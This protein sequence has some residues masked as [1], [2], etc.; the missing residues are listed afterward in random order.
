MIL[1]DL[2]TKLKDLQDYL[3][4][5]GWLHSE[6]QIKSLEKPGEGNMNVVLRI[7][8]D[9]RSFI[10][11]QSRPYVEKYK[12]IEAPLDR[13]AVEYKFYDI[14]QNNA[15]H[16]HMPKI[17]GY[18][19]TNHLLLLEDLGKCEDMIS[20]YHDGDV[21]KKML[22]KLIFILRIIHRTKPPKD[23][24]ENFAMRK[25]N[26][27]H[28]FSLPFK[29]GNGFSLSDIQPGLQ[30]LSMA[31][32]K[33]A[34]LKKVIKNIGKRYLS[35]GNT[36]IHGDYYPGSWMTETENLYV[37]DPEFGFVGF[38]EFDLGVMAAHMIMTTGKKKFLKQI[39]LQYD[40]GVDQKL[41]AQV[42]GIEIMR[43]LIGLAQL[44]L[45]RTL[46]EKAKLLKK[47]RKMILS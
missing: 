44:P 37:I 20:L 32:K 28:I 21:N 30:E 26:H 25:L 9:Q 8:T 27:E 15:L 2:N 24:P 43:R 5:K 16:A 38:A 34:A 39:L 31:Y 7:I 45:E 14:I 29:K 4:S 40:G 11:K 41:V 36:L 47:A 46:E 18:D 42:A 1:F 19:A 13:I 10:L 22:Q 23:F 3:I 33:D 35:K 6:E 12:Q 17:L